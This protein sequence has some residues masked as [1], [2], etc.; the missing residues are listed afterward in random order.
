MRRWSTAGLVGLILFACTLHAGAGA[1]LDMTDESYLELGLRL[2][3]LAIVSEKDLNGD[4]SYENYED[5]VVRRARIRLKGVVNSY[6]SGFAPSGA[7]P[8]MPWSVCVVPVQATG[9]ARRSL[10]SIE[11]NVDR[12]DLTTHGLGLCFECRHSARH[13]EHR[14]EQDLH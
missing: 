10:E 12:L 6:F 4:G 8:S 14:L 2:Q 5:F 13:I 7:T 3:T 9:K 11:P 1:K